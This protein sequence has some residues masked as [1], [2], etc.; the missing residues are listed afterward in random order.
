[1]KRITSIF[2]IIVI[3]CFTLSPLARSAGTAPFSFFTEQSA[4]V[5]DSRHWYYVLADSA[6]NGILISFECDYIAYYTASFGMDF[7]NDRPR[8]QI[9]YDSANAPNTLSKQT[10]ITYSDLKTGNVLTTEIKTASVLSYPAYVIVDFVAILAMSNYL[11]SPRYGYAIGSSKAVFDTASGYNEVSPFVTWDYVDPGTPGDDPTEGQYIVRSRIPRP[12]G[13]G[14]NYYLADHMNLY[15]IYVAYP[16][17]YE[18]QGK[19][20]T[21]L[22]EYEGD[23]VNQFYCNLSGVSGNALLTFTNKSD[24][25]VNVYINKYDVITGAYVSN[26]SATVNAG[27]VDQPSV[28]T[29]TLNLNSATTYGIYQS[30]F[31]SRDGIT[32]FPVLRISWSDTIDYTSDILSIENGVN[33]IVGSASSAVSILGGISSTTQS[34][35]SQI[36][37]F[38]T[39]V[40]DNW[41]WLKTTFYNTLNQKW[42]ITNSYLLSI[43]NLLNETDETYLIDADTSQLNEMESAKNALVVT[44]QNGNNVDPAQAAAVGLSEAASQIGSLSTPVQTINGLMQSIVFDKPILLL[45]LIVGLGLGLMVTIL[46]KNKSD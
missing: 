2:C 19:I 24:Y 21:V 20:D 26:Y 6:D 31:L 7:R 4:P 15:G 1:M 39:L 22:N 17:A 42:D 29:H 11:S 35:L 10:K 12:I 5:P 32:V 33:Q 9:E 41:T 8:F 40:A 14:I 16:P 30:G 28:H 23:T 27:S 46:G 43:Y 18:T 25:P 37:A 3:F 45:P 34:I 36:Q 38:Y 13:N 44:D